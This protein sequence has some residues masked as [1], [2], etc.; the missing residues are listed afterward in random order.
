[1][2]TKRHN[3]CRVRRHPVLGNG[4]DFPG[5]TF[6]THAEIRPDGDDYVVEVLFRCG[7]PDIRRLVG[8]GKASYV[9]DFNCPSVP[10][11]RRNLSTRE[12]R[13]SFRIPASEVADRV[14]VSAYCVA[15]RRIPDYRPEGIHPDY[16]GRFLVLA[17][18]IIAQDEEGT[19]FFE[20][21]SGS[22]SFVKV[23]RNHDPDERIVLWEESDEHFW[24]VL[25]QVDFDNWSVVNKNDPE[26]D[27]N[28]AA[29]AFLLLGVAESVRMLQNE[30]RLRGEEAPGWS[31]ALLN[32]LEARRI[33]P[34]SCEPSEAA[35]TILDRPIGRLLES[36]TQA[37]EE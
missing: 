21:E 32:I 7:D 4:N 30:E 19:K 25:P 13:G 31:R 3:P 15:D 17:A 20:L 5:L 12:E 22:D 16:K 33:D 2:K 26:L 6:S 18:E 35:Q 27:S 11:S 8:E 24:I 14:S 36:I 9:I 23:R 29:P 37:Q 34:L 10:G 28:V 1:M